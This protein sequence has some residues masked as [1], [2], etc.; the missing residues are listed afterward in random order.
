MGIFRKWEA[1]R[2]QKRG[3]H[4]DFP[5]MDLENKE[6]S[7]CIWPVARHA[8]LFENEGSSDGAKE[9]LHQYP[10]VDPGFEWKN[11]MTLKALLGDDK[12]ALI[13][14][15]QLRSPVL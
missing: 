4:A 7:R 10:W 11:S 9:A 15:H 12:S 13:A 3:V 6:Q 1:Q 14:R 2:V 5:L 8:I